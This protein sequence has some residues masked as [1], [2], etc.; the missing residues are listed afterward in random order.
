[1]ASPMTTIPAVNAVVFASYG[2]ARAFIAYLHGDT[3]RPVTNLEAMAAGAFSF[4]PD[5]YIR[6]EVSR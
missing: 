6:H 1:M 5:I 2:Q 4:L 3:E